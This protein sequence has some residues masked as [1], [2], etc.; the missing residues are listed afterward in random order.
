V[1]QQ[2]ADGDREALNNAVGGECGIV[3]LQFTDV[4]TLASFRAEYATEGDDIILHF[5]TLPEDKDNAYWQKM[6]QKVFP[7]TLD[8]VA[9]GYFRAKYPQLKA[10]YTEEMDSW[11]LRAYDFPHILNKDTYVMR[12]LE[13]LDRAVVERR[14]QLGVS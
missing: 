12:F 9:Q 6:W 8:A 1:E 2:V 4:T 11:W 3:P 7:A 5:Y 13:Q 10:A 14:K